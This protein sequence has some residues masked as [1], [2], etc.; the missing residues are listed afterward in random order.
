MAATMTSE[1]GGDGVEPT[2]LGEDIKPI[3]LPVD[4]ASNL[5]DGVS[6][7]FTDLDKP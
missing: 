6:D 1:G 4:D 5:T 2:N 3:A 7:L